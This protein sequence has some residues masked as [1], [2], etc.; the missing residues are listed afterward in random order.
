M[1]YNNSKE[2]LRNYYK[3]K[4]KFLNNHFVHESSEIIFNSL[5]KIIEESQKFNTIMSYM[6][7]ENE[8]KTNQINNYIIRKGK[9]LILP[10]I[11]NHELIPIETSN[12]DNYEIS[13]FGIKEPL[14]KI[15]NEKIDIII[16]PGIV[17]DKNGNRIGFGKGY[18]DKFLQKN[19]S[20]RIA[21]SY[22]FQVRDFIPSEFFDAK[23]NLIITEKNCYNIN[24]F[25]INKI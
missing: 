10:K 11:S 17:F 24:N 5:L 20:C 9:K 16:I 4:R 3:N 15:F 13:K 6:S 2:E 23:M 1:K 22:D 7:F 18:Y 8:V 21:V 14:G 25:F 12:P 19:N